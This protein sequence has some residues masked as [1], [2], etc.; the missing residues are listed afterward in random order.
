VR[1]RKKLPPKGTAERALLAVGLWS[2]MT[3]EEVE[4]IRREIFGSRRSA[5]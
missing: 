4:R 3:P 5:A 2:D 1:K